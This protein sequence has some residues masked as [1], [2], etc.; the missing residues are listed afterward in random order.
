MTTNVVAFIKTKLNDELYNHRYSSTPMTS[1]VFQ[2]HSSHAINEPKK[3]LGSVL[4]SRELTIALPLYADGAE[5]PYTSTDTT[6][7]STP[8][9]DPHQL[10]DLSSLSPTSPILY[11]PPLLSSLPSGYPAP[12]PGLL[13]YTT[14]TRLPN[15]DPASLALHRALHNFQVASPE[16]AR[17]PY[18]EAFNWNELELPEDIEREWYC[19]VFR[20]KRREGSDGGREHL[21]SLRIAFPELTAS[22]SII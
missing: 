6:R 19:V 15:I 7:A 3:I 16:Y 10:P 1:S 4:G 2:S 17:L 20:S 14:A 11:L 5:P 9:R 13:P 18:M 8:A 21:F 12:P 22:F